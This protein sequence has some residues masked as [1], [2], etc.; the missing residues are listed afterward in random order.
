MAT[1]RRLLKSKPADFRAIFELGLALAQNGDVDQAAASFRRVISLNSGFAPAHASL[2]MLLQR[3]GELDQAVIELRSAAELDPKD[4]EVA[5]RLG[6]AFKATKEF[7]AAVEAFR[8]ALELRPDFEKAQYNLG[9]ALKAQ[10]RAEEARA[11]L[12]DIQ[13]LHEFRARLAESKSLILS[14]TQMLEKGDTDGAL[15]QFLSSIEKSPSL[16]AAHYYRRTRVG[17]QAR[18]REGLVCLPTRPR[19][20][21]GLR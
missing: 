10:G 11:E 7:D 20:P 13:G 17:A 19:T 18:D 4:A 9:I 8:R 12:K 2:G 5:Y 1:Y 15:R 3:K 6:M 21:A 14:G 16:S